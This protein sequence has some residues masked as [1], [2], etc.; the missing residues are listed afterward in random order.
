MAN[1][2]AGLV[3]YTPVEFMSRPVHAERK[4]IPGFQALKLKF[5]PTHAAQ[6]NDRTVDVARLSRIPI[7]LYIRYFKPISGLCRSR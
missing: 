7:L 2:M 5:D 1:M 4:Q 6:P 3:V